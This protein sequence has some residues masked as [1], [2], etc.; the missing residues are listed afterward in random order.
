MRSDPDYC[1]AKIA[2]WWC[3]GICCWFG[4]G[5]CDGEWFGKRDH[6][7]HGTG[8]VGQKRPTGSRMGVQS[9]AWLTDPAGRMMALSARLRRV[10]VCCGDWRRVVTPGCLRKGKQVGIFLDPPYAHA[11]GRDTRIYNEE[12][13]N[14]DEVAEFCR[15][16]AADPSVRIVLAG[17]AG[18]YRLPGWTILPWMRPPTVG[19]GTKGRGNSTRERLWLSP[20]SEKTP[21]IRAAIREFRRKSAMLDDAGPR[22]A[23][24]KADPSRRPPPRRRQ[25][26]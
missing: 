22:E 24:P 4:N 7:T 9:G 16:H 20:H 15:K 17:F 1:N 25:R 6:R 10:V 26:R 21:A 5:W 12:M 2:G 19:A 8:L 14:T 3:W 18:E 13:G 11:T 23:T